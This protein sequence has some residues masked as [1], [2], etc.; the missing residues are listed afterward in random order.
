MILLRSP[1]II[2]HRCKAISKAIDLTLVAA[3]IQIIATCISLPTDF[4]PLADTQLS[5]SNGKVW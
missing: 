3:R 1:I 4:Q 5:R 2:L